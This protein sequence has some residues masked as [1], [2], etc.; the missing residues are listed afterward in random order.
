MWPLFIHVPKCGGLSVRYGLRRH[1]TIPTVSTLKSPAYYQALKATMDAAGEHLGLEHARWRDVC[2]ALQA[3]PA[4]ALVRN[5][6]ARCAS[7]Y[8]FARQIVEQG[9][10][11]APAY[12]HITCFEAFL[13]ERHK[14]G[15]REFYWHRAI[16]GWYPQLDHVT[17][18]AGTL[19]CSILRTE[20][21]DEDV[22][23]FLGVKPPRRRNVTLGVRPYRELYDARTID[24][25][26]RHY[27]K[28]IQ[29]FGFSFD[30][31]ATRNLWSGLSS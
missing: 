30:T 28:D 31:P 29:A 4:F 21:L 25:V 26:G 9:T 27:E 18:E 11:Y 1:I 24:I 20:H 7:R 16:R 22:G 17:D 8:F 13:E 6:W 10:I 2:P 14:Y 23:K 15:N 3:L 5:P 19:R 12:K